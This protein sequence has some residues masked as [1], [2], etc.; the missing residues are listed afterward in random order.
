MFLFVVFITTLVYVFAKAFGL[1]IGLV[2]IALVISGIMS[3]G[4]FYYSDKL[5]L[6]TTGARKITKDEYPKYFLLKKLLTLI[7]S[8]NYH[9]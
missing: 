8:T 3:I 4:S 7:F 5:V 6:A 1:S 9:K 2:G